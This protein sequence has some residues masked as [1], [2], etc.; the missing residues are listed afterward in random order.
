[1][2]RA[3]GKFVNVSYLINET[4]VGP[5]GKPTWT[6]KSDAFHPNDDGHAA[7]AEAIGAQLQVR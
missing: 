3:G 1:M 4:N 2:R 6:G 7:L 5:P